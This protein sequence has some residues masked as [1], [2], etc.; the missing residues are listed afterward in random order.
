MSD[1]LASLA[2]RSLNT[3]PVIT[4]R[5]ASLFEPAHA[6]AGLAADTTLEAADY[7]SD[8]PAPTARQTDPPDQAVPGQSYV[9]ELL[10]PHVDLREPAAQQRKK[11]DVDDDEPET[12][13]P[14]DSPLDRAANA[15]SAVSSS[16]AAPLNQIQNRPA[17]PRLSLDPERLRMLEP[18][19]FSPEAVAGEA[20]RRKDEPARESAQRRIVTEQLA[21]HERPRSVEHPQPPAPSAVAVARAATLPVKPAIRTISSERAIS[22]PAPTIRV[23]IGRVE[24][25]AIM[26][27]TPAARQAPA[28]PGS[29]SLADYLKQREGGNR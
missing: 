27:E 11:P 21:S 23:T 16:V 12:K 28:R 10:V 2:A 29:L 15:I 4:P 9:G 20:S 26:P 5:L 17:S 13:D 25:K 1:Y 19:R 14:V 18:A 7:Q 3:A 22:E 24:V 6:T 8:V